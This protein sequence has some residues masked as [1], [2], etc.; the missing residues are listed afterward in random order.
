M[1][2]SRSV[3]KRVL[4]TNLSKYYW[5]VVNIQSTKSED[6]GKYWQDKEK[7]VLLDENCSTNYETGEKNEIGIAD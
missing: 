4:T 1:I 2:T 5:Q 7:F 6:G 3:R